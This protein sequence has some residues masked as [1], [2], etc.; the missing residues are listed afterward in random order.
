[1]QVTCLTF[2]K[3]LY[4]SF[5]KLSFSW[6]PLC[7]LHFPASSPHLSRIW[8]QSMLSST[9]WLWKSSAMRIWRP[10][11]VCPP[12]SF[13]RQRCAVAATWEDKLRNR[14][15]TIRYDAT[16]QR[17][18]TSLQPVRRSAILN[19]R[20]CTEQEKGCVQKQLAEGPT[21]PMVLGRKPARYIEHWRVCRVRM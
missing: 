6:A 3:V 2:G 1:M 20:N 17:V 7:R 8:I 5:L 21:S 4:P 11:S 10:V 9:T 12:K 14:N 19:V 15:T 16:I 13:A 18:M